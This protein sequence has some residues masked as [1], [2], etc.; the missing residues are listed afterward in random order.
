[1]FKVPKG[2][3]NFDSIPMFPVEDYRIS[4]DD[5]I[6]FEMYTNDGAVIIDNMS[7]VSPNRV[8]AASI[9]EYVVRSNGEVELPVIGKINI[10]GL[11]IEQCE[12]TLV[13]KFTSYQDPFIQVRVTNQRVIVFPGNGSDAKVIPLINSNT[14][15]MEA[16]AQAGGITERGK[17]N[18]VK[19]M[20]KVNGKREVYGMDLSTIDG[21]RHVDMIVQANDYIYVEPTPDLAKELREDV[22][23]VVSLVS[24]ALFIFSAI[25]S[26]QK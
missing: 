20:R 23:P 3:V 11:T 8:N 26:L 17:A 18:T 10:E 15:L 9:R 24:S 6:T 25:L 5:K 12:D 16:I 7:G 1:M 2:E 4:P 22:V 14:T 21:L 13:S 19:L